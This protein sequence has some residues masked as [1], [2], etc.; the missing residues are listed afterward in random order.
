MKSLTPKRFSIVSKESTADEVLIELAKKSFGEQYES[1]DAKT[2]HYNLGKYEILGPWFNRGGTEFLMIV[3]GDATVN[4]VPAAKGDIIRIDVG[5]ITSVETNNGCGITTH[6]F[7][8]RKNL[9]HVNFF[10]NKENDLSGPLISIIIIAKDIE[11]YIGHSI[12]SCLQQTYKNIQII[13]VDDGS[14]DSTVAKSL[15]MA[16]YDKRVEVYSQE[17]GVNGVRKYGLEKM[18]GE[19][20][21][22]IDGDDWINK[23]TVEILVSTAIKTGSEFI[24]FGFDHYNQKNGK[25]WDHVYPRYAEEKKSKMYDEKNKQSALFVSQLNHTIWMYFV[26]AKLKDVAISS[27]ID[28]PLYEDIPYS[29]SL[30]Q[31]AKNPSLC[32]YIFY[33]YR[34]S[35]PGQ[36]TGNWLTINSAVKRMYLEL[37]IKHTISILNKEDWFH[38]LILLYKTRRIFDHEF[39]LSESANDHLSVR[40]WEKTWKIIARMFPLMLADRIDDEI[41]CNS[42]LSAHENVDKIYK[43][44]WFS[45]LTNKMLNVKNS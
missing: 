8:Y 7:P 44:G 38:Q 9:F 2:K 6:V 5:N 4:G 37:S 12:S 22:I 41:I 33:H 27:L 20:F 35:R 32:N 18:R 28:I 24:G 16:S 43:A 45:R 11:H 39:N 17:L 3:D 31:V 34:R 10:E 36:A 25:T 30:M 13:V 1:Y 15:N 14:K 19:Y 29:I 26:S 40:G 42:F 23:D 21:L